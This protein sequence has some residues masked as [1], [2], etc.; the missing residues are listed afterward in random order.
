MAAFGPDNLKGAVA[1]PSQMVVGSLT[2]FALT[3]QNASNSAVNAGGSAEVKETLMRTLGEKGTPVIIG[4]FENTGSTLR[5]AFENTCGWS[6][7]TLDA[8]LKALGTV[9]SIDLS[10]TDAVAFVY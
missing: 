8:A 2:H 7:S 4:T 6:A 3:F 9:D 1:I 5:V 10:G